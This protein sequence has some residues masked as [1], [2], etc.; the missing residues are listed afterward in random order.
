MKNH[1]M[2][3]LLWAASLPALAHEGHDDTPAVP[4]ASSSPQRLPDGSV[5]LPKASQRQLAIRTILTEQKQLPRTLE[6]AGKV[7]ADPNAGGKVQAAFAGRVEAGPRGLPWL[8]QAVRK[9]EVLATIRPVA[10]AIET[11]NQAA[12]AAELRAGKT[13]AEQRLARLQQL[14]GS[15]P[16]KEIDAARLDVQSMGERLAAV[17]GSIA[18]AEA[19]RA[20]VS[21]VVAAA[22]VVAG[23][24]V[25][26][27]ELLFEIVDPARLR[28]EAVAYDAA[29]ATNIASA[30]ASP[31]AGQSFAL[32]FVGAGRILREQA[33]PLQ[34]RVRAEQGGAAPLAVGQP[35]KVL[36]QTR[37]LL[38]GVAVPAAAVV[39]N[40]SN[41][42]IVW[43][44]AE[45]LRFAPKPVRTA[46]LDGASVIVL[47]GL[48]AAERV[49]VQ[50]ASLL[51]QVR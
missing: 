33:I 14:E 19:L 43:V 50:G 5:L 20:P 36:V 46:P 11:A 35:L 29:L 42:D 3:G 38:K 47:D 25:D 2:I 23:Q 37:T 4:V 39:K 44:H 16:R 49:V 41:Q 1:L 6:L 31:Q 17:R 27:R 9:G 18:T 13:L 7:L 30:S 40:A 51:N 32:D 24:L 8:G 34:F 22:S 48:G 26:A 15:V 12:Q 28:V 10:G 45:A 21:G